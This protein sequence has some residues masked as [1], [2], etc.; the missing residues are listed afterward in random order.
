GWRGWRSFRRTW[1]LMLAGRMVSAVQVVAGLEPPGRRL[2]AAEVTRLRPIFDDSLDYAAVRVKEGKLGVL[3][4]TGRAFAHG[5]TVFIPA[6]GALDFGLLVH[7]LTHVWQHQ[8]G[9]T[10]YL[11]AALFA[12]WLGDGYDWRKAVGQEL[13][14]HQLNPEQQAQLVED[15][16]LSDLIPPS[17]PLPP[18]AKLKGWTEAALPLLAEALD[19]LRSGRGAP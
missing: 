10:A 6:R 12:Q 13:R 5:N 7:E 9:G 4:V 8:H 15:A 18:R 3:G 19:C 1:W 16:A 17:V 11:S 2:T 14:W